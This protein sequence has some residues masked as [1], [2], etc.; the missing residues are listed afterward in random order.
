MLGIVN[1]E[2][3]EEIACIYSVLKIGYNQ[4]LTISEAVETS[5]EIS[6]ASYDVLENI[7]QMNRFSNL[8]YSGYGV[9]I[10][11]IEPDNFYDITNPHLEDKNIIVVEGGTT[12]GETTASDH[13]TAMMSM[14]CGQRINGYSGVAPDA[15]VYFAGGATDV[16]IMRQY[17]YT[18]VV[19]KNVSILNM[20]IGV[21]GYSSYGDFD[22]YIDCFIEQYRSYN[23]S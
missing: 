6:I 5:N 8:D 12:I 22:N 23:C 2:Y 11:V 3:I 20:S 4:P 16:N 15:T 21:I 7:N 18:L 9:K 17:M 13:P 10:G 19:E 14:I 1:L